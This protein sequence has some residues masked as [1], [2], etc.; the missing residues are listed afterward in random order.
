MVSWRAR[1]YTMTNKKTRL[2]PSRK[3]SG[4]PRKWAERAR[5]FSK[6]LAASGRTFSDSTEIVRADRDSR[7]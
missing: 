4:D 2:K 7:T 5:E 3:A 6:K 1:R